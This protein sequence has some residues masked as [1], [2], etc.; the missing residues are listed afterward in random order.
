VKELFKF[1]QHF[2]EFA[3]TLYSGTF[4]YSQ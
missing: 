1:G 2:G 3:G 4:F